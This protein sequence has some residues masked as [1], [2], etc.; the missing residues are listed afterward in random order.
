MIYLTIEFW[1]VVLDIIG[2]SL[3]GITILHLMKNKSKYNQSLLKESGK[4]NSG[5]IN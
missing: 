2:L 5:S 3:C 1:K 4:R